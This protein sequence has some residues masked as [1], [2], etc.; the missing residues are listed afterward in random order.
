MRIA[1]PMLWL[2]VAQADT[3]ENVGPLIPVASD[4]WPGIILMMV[5]GI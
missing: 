3:A 1:M 5:D 2:A 4:N